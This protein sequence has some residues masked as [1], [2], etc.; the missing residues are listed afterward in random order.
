[1]EGIATISQSIF[2]EINI[3]LSDLKGTESYPFAEGCFLPDNYKSGYYMIS[4]GFCKRYIFKNTN[5]TGEKEE[6]YADKVIMPIILY[7]SKILYVNGQEEMY[8]NE[9]F[10]C[11]N[12][13]FSSIQKV[14]TWLKKIN[15][16][17]W[18]DGDT[19][20]LVC[21]EKYI[22]FYRNHVEMSVKQATTKLGWRKDGFSPYN[23]VDIF[24][25]DE[26]IE[27]KNLIE[28]FSSKGDFELWKS[29]TEKYCKNDT[30][31]LYINTSLSAPLISLTNR[32]S[33]WVHNHAK[34]STGKTPAIYASASIYG[35]PD[36]YAPAF[37]T[38]RAGLEFKLNL[39]GNLPAL[40]DD[41]QN[42]NDWGRKHI[43]TLVYDVCNGS[44]KTR[45]NIN[46]EIQQCKYWNTTMLTNGEQEL[47]QG[48]EYEGA[49]KR[50]IEIDTIPFEDHKEAREAREIYMNN[51]G[52]CG[53]KFIKILQKYKDEII[54]L[55]FFIEDS[56]NNDYNFPTH[57][58]NMASLAVSDYIFYRHILKKEKDIA[59]NDSISWA[60]RILAILPKEKEIDKITIGLDLVEE[61]VLSNVHRF[62]TE[63]PQG[64]IGFFKDG[65][66]YFYRN[67][68]LK[69]LKLWNIPE[70][71]FLKEI[72][73]LDFVLTDDTGRFKQ[74][75][76]Q[77]SNIR[78]I[79][80]NH[81]N[82]TDL[83][84]DISQYK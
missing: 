65:E 26:N 47:L 21:L 74:I 80:F 14:K 11:E 59:L 58:Q 40:F 77:G 33:F 35:K 72:K 49:T 39:L 6:L 63:C 45:G 31:R 3:F 73:N 52:F 69:L 29:A 27:I 83:V 48:N 43:S 67:E 56:I 68:F 78:P 30:F 51:Y 25:K 60:K 36:K 76:H 71:R 84:E 16:T 75:K 13:T 32:P 61:F 41:S 79:G 81:I 57:I 22:S 34:H 66:I 24:V 8:F 42:L 4:K 62:R 38:T 46:G 18:F 2:D 44:G 7:P 10:L 19:K 12:D 53:E 82:L 37:N 28:S 1:M 50:L 5:E 15:K 23:N 55:A 9:K 64:R 17:L 70:K 20:D 54:D